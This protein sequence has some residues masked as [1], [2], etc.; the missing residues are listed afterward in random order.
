MSTES[1]QQPQIQLEKLKEK[2]FSLPPE[3]VNVRRA[4]ASGV[5]Q[6]SYIL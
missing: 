6:I 4:T 5:A 3:T 2:V 1:K